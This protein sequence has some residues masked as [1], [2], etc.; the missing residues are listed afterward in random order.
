MWREVGCWVARS[1]HACHRGVGIGLVSGGVTGLHQIVR[2]HTKGAVSVWCCWPGVLLPGPVRTHVCRRAHARTVWVHGTCHHSV[3]AAGWERLW[4]ER[5]WV[6]GRAYERAVR[7]GGLRE[8]IG[9]G[10]GGAVE[11][12]CLFRCRRY[13]VFRFAAE[14]VFRTLH[15]GRDSRR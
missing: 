4:V 3:C 12:W 2:I 15:V 6:R 13:W 5:T 10:R 14:V 7:H 9:S 1:G 11:A 8:G